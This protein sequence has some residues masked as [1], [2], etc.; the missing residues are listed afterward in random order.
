MQDVKPPEIVSKNS[1]KN[2]CWANGI[3]CNAKQ[4]FSTWK[5]FLDHVPK[6]G[7][8]AQLICHGIASGTP[9]RKFSR[10]SLKMMTPSTQSPKSRTLR[11]CSSKS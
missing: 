7:P 1:L 3:T 2:M 11:N 6:S 4:N 5:A 10:Q 8:K 9:S